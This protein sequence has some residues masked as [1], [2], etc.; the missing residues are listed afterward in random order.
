MEVAD[1]RATNVRVYVSLWL[2]VVA[3]IAYVCR[4]SIAVAEDDIRASLRISEDDMGL[5][6]GPAFFW[7]YAAAQIPTAWVT[8]QY[9]SRRALTL[10][11]FLGAG[12]IAMTSLVQGFWDLTGARVAL[13]IAQAGLF[14][15]ATMTIARWHPLVERA[16]AS[17]TLGA[18]MQ[19]GHALGLVLTGTLIGL[20]GWRWGLGLGAVPAVLWAVGFWLWFRDDPRNHR[21]V[22]RAELEVIGVAPSTNAGGDGPAAAQAGGERGTPWGVI[23][24][25]TT[26]RLIFGQQFFRAAGQVFFATWFPK[27]LK[28]TRGVEL[29]ESAWMSA[30]PVLAAMVSALIGGG[31]SD[32]V[33]RLTGS[34]DRARKGIAWSSQLLCAVTVSG[35]YFMADPM[36]AVA[37]ISLGMF[38]AGF[39]GPCAYSVTIDVGGRHVPAV[40]STMNMIGN[41]GAGLL[42]LI[43]PQF[44]TSV[45]WLL[46]RFGISGLNGWD[47][48]L[49]LF[50]AMYLAAALCWMRL[51]IVGSVF[52]QRVD[53]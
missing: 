10:F 36:L 33:Y 25:S 52:D 5:I 24:R 46:G 49:L 22:N 32:R 12:A 28:E 31:I 16:R 38:F 53:E 6:F 37:T 40:F 14:P 50:A 11:S 21:S 27:Y 7:V 20:F 2:A 39:A 18:S 9:G 44:R 34:L 45:D 23:A 3:A 1:Y 29:G 15:A 51:R 17:G 8:K 26:L 19:L 41:V 4:T 42:A 48:V 47:F 43:V 13:G 30:A 35:A